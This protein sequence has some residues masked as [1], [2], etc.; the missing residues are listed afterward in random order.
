MLIRALAYVGA[1]ALTV[2]LVAGCAAIL[3][4]AKWDVE[5]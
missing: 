4:V 1:W 3:V 5:P 2:A